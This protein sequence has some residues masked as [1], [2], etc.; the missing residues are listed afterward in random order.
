MTLKTCVMKGPHTVTVNPPVQRRDGFKLTSL[1]VCYLDQQQEP[2]PLFL[3]F[4]QISSVFSVQAL[5]ALITV[6]PLW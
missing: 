2:L 5:P 6:L 3:S 4:R 1:T